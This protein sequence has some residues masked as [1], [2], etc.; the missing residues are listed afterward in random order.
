MRKVIIEHAG[1]GTYKIILSLY[2]DGK[3]FQKFIHQSTPD[4]MKEKNS[5]EII[6]ETGV[7]FTGMVIEWLEKNDPENIREWVVKMVE[8]SNNFS[9]KI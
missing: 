5:E 2:L 4:I 8:A 6:K 9:K 1:S 7:N 3:I